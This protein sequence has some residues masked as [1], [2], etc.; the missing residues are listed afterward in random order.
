[1]LA[2]AVEAGRTGFRGRALRRP[3]YDDEGGPCS[4]KDLLARA[5]ADAQERITPQLITTRFHEVQEAMHRMKAEI[6]AAKLDALVGVGDEQ[7]ELF[8]DQDMPAIAIY[9]GETIRNAPQKPVAEGDWYRR[10]QM[11]R[12][13]E[14]GEVHYP[15][16]SH[17]ALHLIDALVEREFDLSA[18][19]APS[20]GQ[21]EGD[22]YSVV[23]RR[24][25]QDSP[26]PIVS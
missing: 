1:M 9:Y 16:H 4:Y 20:P 10:A 12:L 25:P 14:A 5:P 13:E 22:A 2:A 26:P 21:D 6:A 15:C 18:L 23:H 3:Y 11:R 24:D 7:Y 8:G 19:A 17:L